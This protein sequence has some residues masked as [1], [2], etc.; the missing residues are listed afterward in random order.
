MPIRYT[1]TLTNLT[2][3]QARIITE[4]LGLAAGS[5]ASS[6]ND[7]DELRLLHAYPHD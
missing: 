5:F 3:R 4:A 7:F 2:E 6:S 1:I